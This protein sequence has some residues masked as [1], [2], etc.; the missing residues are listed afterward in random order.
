M[1]SKMRSQFHRVREA[2]LLELEDIEKQFELEV[3]WFLANYHE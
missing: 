3:L 2:D 1:I